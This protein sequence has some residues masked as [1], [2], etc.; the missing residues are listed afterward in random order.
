MMS[1]KIVSVNPYISTYSEGFR[2]NA[3][4][5]NLEELFQ[6]THLYFTELNK[7][8]E[9]FDSYVNKQKAFLGNL[10]AS[11]Q[12]YFQKELGEFIYGDSPRYTGFPTPEKMDAADYD[13]AYKKYQERFADAGDFHFYFVG[14][15][16]EAKLI[17]MDLCG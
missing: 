1:G 16:D 10:L 8:E 5:K 17:G 9:A 15:I 13:L 4:P 2:G 11:P 14:N 7:D 6:L 12:F 3:A